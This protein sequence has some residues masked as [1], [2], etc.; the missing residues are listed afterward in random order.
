MDERELLDYLIKSN[1]E[2]Q[3]IVKEYQKSTRIAVIAAIISIS[4]CS[5]MF[6]ITS[7]IQTS[8]ITHEWSEG[9]RYYF[10]TDYE[11]GTVEQTNTQ[12]VDLGGNN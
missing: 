8:K 5:A 3:K 9:I 7:T 12:T 4:L 10:K 1:E 6:C 2:T 11:Y